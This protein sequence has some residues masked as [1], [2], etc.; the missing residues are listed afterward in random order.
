MI[1][2]AAGSGPLTASNATGN[3]IPV[4]TPSINIP[5][6]TNEKTE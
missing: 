4:G 5:T 3:I 6:T 2:T 1:S